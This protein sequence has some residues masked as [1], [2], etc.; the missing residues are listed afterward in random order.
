MPWSTLVEGGPRTRLGRTAAIK[1]SCDRLSLA[2]YV[3]CSPHCSLPS[4]KMYMLAEP[5]VA[6]RRQKV[7]ALGGRSA[8]APPPAHHFPLARR[9][10]GSVFGH[11]ITVQPIQTKRLLLASAR[12][13]EVYTQDGCMQV[14]AESMPGNSISRLPCTCPTEQ[15]PEQCNET[16]ERGKPFQCSSRPL[17]TTH[18]R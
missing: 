5:L 13:G 7:G 17:F 18:I 14:V 6:D 12:L 16:L 15:H 9:V 3:E 1:T 8:R 4:P 2:Q 11:S 10:S